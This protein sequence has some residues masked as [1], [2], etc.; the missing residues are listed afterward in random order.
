MHGIEKCVGGWSL[1][2]RPLGKQIRVTVNGGTEEAVLKA[3]N[4]VERACKTGDFS[5]LS[6]IGREIARTSF[7]KSGFEPPSELLPDRFQPQIAQPGPLTLWGAVELFLNYPTIREDEANRE[8]HIYALKHIVG[9]LGRQTAVEDIWVPEVRAY[10]E[11]RKK[12][13]A[14]NTTINREKATL[15]K[16]FTVLEELRE[17]PKNPC[18]LVKRLSTKASERKVYISYSDAVDLFNLLPEW[19]RPIAQ[20][21]Y[22]TGMRVGEVHG[23]QRS[24]VDLDR[25]M[26]FLGPK[27]V[28]EDDWKKIP[29]HRELVSVLES[30]LRATPTFQ[31]VLFV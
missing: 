14:A 30:C 28:K 9:F 22:Y 6:G 11:S 10:M 17:V 13:G 8:R 19:L 12:S 2:F 5:R 3:R 29:I 25:R 31:D 21:V 24:R 15:S 4:E 23:L 16:L 20:T 26:I 7:E 27:M 18:K 1:R